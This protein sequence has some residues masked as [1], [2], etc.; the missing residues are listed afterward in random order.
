[1]TD[2]RFS[3]RS[4]SWEARCV[5]SNRTEICLD[6]NIRIFLL[7]ETDLRVCRVWG[8]FTC[9][10]GFVRFE[11]L[12]SD[13]QCAVGEAWTLPQIPQIVWEPALGDFQY[14][15]VRLTWDI[16]GV[17]HYTHLGRGTNR[18]TRLAT[19]GRMEGWRASKTLK[20][21]QNECVIKET[22]KKENKANLNSVS[23]NFTNRL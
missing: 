5:E 12:P 8:S 6:L 10:D 20:Q 9:Q 13:T 19:N 14:V 3:N 22:K 4:W 23:N 2:L 7:L 15:C 21:T 16:Y 17:L 18:K 1:M 11:L